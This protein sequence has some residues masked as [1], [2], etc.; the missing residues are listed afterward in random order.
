ML[1]FSFMS[2]SLCRLSLVETLDCEYRLNGVY[3]GSYSCSVGGGAY[4]ILSWERVRTA[5]GGEYDIWYGCPVR[6]STLELSL[7]LDGEVRSCLGL[8]TPRARVIDP[9]RKKTFVSVQ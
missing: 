2:F 5:M 3:I 7:E 4:V 1:T 9:Y 8:R 6:L